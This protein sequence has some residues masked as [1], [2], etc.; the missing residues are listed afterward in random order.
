MLT[1]MAFTLVEADGGR[2]AFGDGASYSFNQ[3][4]FLVVVDD[5]GTR[6]TYSHVAWRHVED[7]PRS[8][9]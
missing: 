3:A 5:S 2:V 1:V 9:W 6:L 7:V 8:G 4:G